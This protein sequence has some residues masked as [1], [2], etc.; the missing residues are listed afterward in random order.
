[1][2]TKEKKHLLIVEDDESVAEGLAEI[3]TG[4]EYD[5]LCTDN[6]EGA[7]E[8]LRFGR[9]DLIILDICLGEENGYDLCRKIRKRWNTPIIFLT[10]L[11]N[12]IEI[13]RGFHAGGGLYYETVSYAGIAG[14]DTGTAAPQRECAKQP[15]TKRGTD[16]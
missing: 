4:Y 5:V 3:L 2:S 9:V 1:M 10:A 12:E 14:S 11:S 16:L 8:Q 15:E 6:G 7:M 13:V